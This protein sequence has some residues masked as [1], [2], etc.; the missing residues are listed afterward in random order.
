M[1]RKLGIAILTILLVCAAAAVMATDTLL[2]KIKTPVDY[3]ANSY[4]DSGPTRTEV[5]SG[6]GVINS[7]NFS[8]GDEL[9]L[10]KDTS[11]STPEIKVCNNTGSTVVVRFYACTFA[12]QCNCSPTSY[13]DVTLRPNECYS[14]TSSNCARR[15]T[16][17]NPCA[18]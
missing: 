16:T 4:T 17:G 7:Y 2:W 12:Q 8:I 11:I 3:T 13:T 9:S 14:D 18:N 15:C 10:Q 6:G 1:S 5:G